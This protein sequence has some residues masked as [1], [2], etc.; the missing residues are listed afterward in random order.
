MGVA[1]VDLGFAGVEVGDPAHGRAWQGGDGA[2][3]IPGDGDRECADG[4]GLVDHDDDQDVAEVDGVLAW[5]WHIP[6]VWL[7]AFAPCG[8]SCRHPRHEALPHQAVR[9]SSP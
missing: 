3:G 7:A 5:L 6:P 1:G 8:A 9:R 4:G 2:S